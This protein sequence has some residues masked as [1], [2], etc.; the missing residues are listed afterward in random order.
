MSHFIGGDAWSAIV[1]RGNGVSV[2]VSPLDHSG[3]SDQGLGPLRVAGDGGRRTPIPRPLKGAPQVHA[4][5]QKDSKRV[6]V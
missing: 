6:A 4:G 1:L 5:R 2:S 3:A